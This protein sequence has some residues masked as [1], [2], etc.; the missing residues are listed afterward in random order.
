[1]AGNLEQ[2]EKTWRDVLHS[3]RC[4]PVLG[5]VP[6]SGEHSESITGLVKNA[7]LRI[8]GKDQ[9]RALR[10]LLYRYPA[11]T[12]VWLARKA[13]EAYNLGKF[14][15]DFERNIGAKIA[16]MERP[17]LAQS[18]REACSVVMGNYTSP[19]EPGA[20]RH[21]EAFLF[22]AGLPLCHCD[23]FARLVRQVERRYGLP[24]LD[25]P[26]AGEE[27]QEYILGS[28]SAYAPPML[29][30]ALQGPAGPLIC[31]C[32][33]RVV[34]EGDYQG[35]NPGLGEALKE[36]FASQSGGQLRRSARQPFLRL[37]EDYSSL[38]IVGPR[39]DEND[40]GPEG[41]SW[42]V[43][44]TL[45]PTASFDEFVYP[46]H[47]SQQISIELRGLRSGVTATR[48]FTSRLEDKLQPFMIFGLGSRRLRREESG[49]TIWL[50]SGDYYLLHSDQA[51][52]LPEGECWDWPD[53]ERALSLLQVRP[54]REITLEDISTWS[55][56]AAP[57]PF[58][59]TG[60][61]SVLA[62]NGE[63][64]CY[65]WKGLPQ[66]CRPYD[67][68]PRREGGWAVRIAVAAV[69]R[70]YPLSD[71]QIEGATMRCRLPSLGELEALPPGLHEID[72]SVIQRHRCHL[73]QSYLLWVGLNAYVPGEKFVLSAPPIN[74]VKAGCCGFE[75]SPFAIQHQSDAYR[76]HHLAFDLRGE[77][78]RLAWSRKGIFLESL[79]RTP[80]RPSEP[81]SNKLGETFSASGDSQRWLRVWCI[82]AVP[83]HLK[84]NNEVLQRMKAEQNHAFFDVSLAQISTL[85]PQGGSIVLKWDDSETTV[86]RFARPLTPTRVQ[87][88]AFH[89]SK[90][91]KF[92]FREQ[93]Q[94]VKPRLLE[95]VTGRVVEFA[96][97][98]LGTSE[99]GVFCTGD[100]P[101][102][103]CFLTT[104]A[105]GSQC[106]SAIELLVPK[107]DWPRG[108]WLV[109]LQVS[110]DEGSDWEL[111]TDSYGRRAP[112]IVFG[113]LDGATAGSPLEQLIKCEEEADETAH[114][115]DEFVDT[116]HQMLVQAF[117]NI[118]Q[119]VQ[120][121]FVPD[122]RTELGWLEHIL[123]RAAH[124]VKKELRK[125]SRED[126]SKL[127]LLLPPSGDQCATDDGSSEKH[128]GIVLI[129]E[130]L[131]LSAEHY[132][133]V[134]V[135]HPLGSSL[136]WC[137]FLAT[138]DFVFEA[139]RNMIEDAFCS[140]QSGTPETF[141]VLK[142]FR[143]FP[144]VVQTNGSGV[145]P[146][147]FARFDYRRYFDETVGCIDDV[148][149]QLEWNTNRV[150]GRTHARWALGQFI[151]RIE[152][153]R[154]NQELGSVN[155]FFCNAVQFLDWLTKTMGDY[156]GLV[157]PDAGNNP[158]L[159]VSIEE[160]AIVICSNKFAS[161]FA[162]AAR[163]ASAGWLSFEDAM[164]WLIRIGGDSRITRQAI[165]TLVGLA[166]E[167][168]GFY[169]MFWELMKRTYPHD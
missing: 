35:I 156:Q 107:C 157:P 85:Y 10:I 77:V 36:A 26:E 33:L 79:Q 49:R 43:N 42:V 133:S 14:W 6:L 78:K 37:G 148:D 27:L 146:L 76:Q 143:N 81:I 147:D 100:L 16:S 71:G 158:W 5:L 155:A 65:G 32:A 124:A 66:I 99:E 86:A 48:T 115:S 25:L 125:S 98:D 21:V 135:N 111:V 166:P 93:I 165:A 56:R 101:E 59:E 9:P 61:R 22:Q 144:V 142:D 106:R 128:S 120:C 141:A 149:A 54:E 130:L 50:P 55:F 13:G 89:E 1:M 109:E 127:L 117:S 114:T 122:L 153:A 116:K 140:S 3:D 163:A 53:G 88:S 68:D 131:A 82:P 152:N 7:M 30:R 74:L 121:G 154:E 112:L 97:Q 145:E 62:D 2:W 20:F 90:S 139:F 159:R 138:Y 41:L 38:E 47:D 104:P 63:S 113:G 57:I 28:F 69:V 102:L 110:R 17:N 29:R 73:K 70:T 167:L 96:G 44:G 123:E 67:E 118:L 52:I 80:G 84:I 39:Q 83:A 160:P 75:V 58:I 105:K 132:V 18:F 64:I 164:Q 11:V 31:Q 24:D 95:L 72:I 46:L 150:L 161:V 40:I 15:E 119:V 8:P 19:P 134:S 60:G 45:Y 137:G 151:K 168:F 4:P 92:L 12:S 162:M 87:F 91:V 103:R 169:L 34:F 23:R 94:W 129:P 136:L 108:L 51:R 126:V